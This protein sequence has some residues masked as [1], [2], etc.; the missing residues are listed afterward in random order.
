MLPK[1]LYH[2]CA[3][4]QLTGLSIEQ[5]YSRNIS[6]CE[7]I[8][9]LIFAL[10]QSDDIESAVL[11]VSEKNNHLVANFELR[12]SG[13]PYV[14]ASNLPA[15]LSNENGAAPFSFERVINRDGNVSEDPSLFEARRNGLDAPLNNTV[16]RPL[17]VPSIPS[18]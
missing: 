5:S 1:E 6:H 3:V 11:L 14:H 17:R 8:D 12:H 2:K 7:F 13:H 4:G 15:G 16:G 9:D 18:S 10:I